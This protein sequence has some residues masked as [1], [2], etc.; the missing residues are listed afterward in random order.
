MGQSTNRLGF[1]DEY[2]LNGM[3]YNETV[4]GIK[5]LIRNCDEKIVDEILSNFKKYNEDYKYTRFPLKVL[6]DLYRK[7]KLNDDFL[8]IDELKKEYVNIFQKYYRAHSSRYDH[9]GDILKN[10]QSYQELIKEQNNYRE[11]QNL[12]KIYKKKIKVTK[13]S[14][15]FTLILFKYVRLEDDYDKR[16]FLKKTFEEEFS[17]SCDVDY[18]NFITKEKEFFELCLD[19][20]SQRTAKKKINVY[21][22]NED[23]NDNDNDYNNYSYDNNNNISDSYHSCDYRHSTVNSSSNRN[24]YNSTHS[25]NS[26]RNTSNKNQNNTKK[27][28]K[29][30]MCYS[31]KG[32]NKCPLCGNKISKRVSLGNLYAHSNCYNEGTCCLCNKKGPGNHVQSIC[33]DCRKGSISKGLTGSARCFICRKLV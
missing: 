11:Y 16:Q 23:Y 26:P 9:F 20:E 30:I 15:N 28:V 1:L 5:G 24:N 6:K 25:S 22:D 33:S 13:L 2:K 8:L 32:K 29:V 19:S 12:I 18:E 4:N 17:I 21:Y 7:K 31:C 10:A 14:F 27:K 3:S